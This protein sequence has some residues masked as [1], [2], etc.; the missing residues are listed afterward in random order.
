[1]T[2][3]ALLLQDHAVTDHRID[4]ARHHVPPRR[5]HIALSGSILRLSCLNASR[6]LFGHLI[7][8]VSEIGG[9]HFGLRCRILSLR[10]LTW[11]CE[12]WI[13]DLT[14][15]KVCGLV[16]IVK[17]IEGVNLDLL[18]IELHWVNFADAFELVWQIATSLL[19]QLVDRHIFWFVE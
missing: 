9:D 2:I 17:L 6:F 4:A 11:V 14:R 15:G 18:A 8:Q 1:M 3:E 16:E 5:S 19:D 13:C 10:K 12:A 7:L